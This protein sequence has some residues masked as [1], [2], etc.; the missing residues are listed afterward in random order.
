MCNS[1]SFEFEKTCKSRGYVRQ[2]LSTFKTA[3]LTVATDVHL[4]YGL[5]SVVTIK[6][7]RAMTY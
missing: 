1:I 5:D 7:M 6:Q 3:H 2:K 4:Y